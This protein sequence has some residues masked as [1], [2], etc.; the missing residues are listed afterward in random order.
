LTY[1]S[2]QSPQLLL[3]HILVHGPEYGADFYGVP[4]DAEELYTMPS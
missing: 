2:R 3:S 1:S 4:A